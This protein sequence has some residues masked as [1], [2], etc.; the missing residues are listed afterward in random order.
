[1]YLSVKDARFGNDCIVLL[2]QD[3]VAFLSSQNTVEFTAS[4][5]FSQHNPFT[6]SKKM[7]CDET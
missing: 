3:Q 5:L 1:M 4:L 2:Q 7:K 6:P